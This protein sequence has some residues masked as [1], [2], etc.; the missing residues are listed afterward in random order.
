MSRYYSMDDASWEK[1]KAKV[2]TF[3]ASNDIGEMEQVIIWNMTSGDN[4][5]DNRR[6]YWT[7]I[8]TL[9]G[10]LPN[11]PLTGEETAEEAEKTRKEEEEHNDI[12][13][14]ISCTKGKC[15]NDYHT[16][17]MYQKTNDDEYELIEE[18]YDGHFSGVRCVECMPASYGECYECRIYTKRTCRIK[19]CE[20]KIC[21]DC[22]EIKGREA[23][24]WYHV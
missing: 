1:R 15:K 24:D 22:K 20:I 16:H 9:F 7:S 10:M 3:L 23:H 6:R 17:S 13:S 5:A 8:T 14:A 21:R 2:S 19:D 11:S 12:M 18:A 4:D